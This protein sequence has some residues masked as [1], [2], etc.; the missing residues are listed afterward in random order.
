MQFQNP[1]LGKAFI[2]VNQ[3]L[4]INIFGLSLQIQFSFVPVKN[5]GGDKREFYDVFAKQVIY[6][7][8][9][10]NISQPGG[11]IARACAKQPDYHHGRLRIRRI[12]LGNGIKERL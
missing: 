3:V 1:K 12:L 10:G 2:F 9:G 7:I 5:P 8:H 6:R 11:P 4:C